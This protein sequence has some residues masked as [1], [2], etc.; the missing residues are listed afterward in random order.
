MGVSVLNGILTGV[1]RV[2]HRGID[3]IGDHGETDALSLTAGIKA[4][5]A[6][7][8]AFEIRFGDAAAVVADGDDDAAALVVDGVAGHATPRAAA[9]VALRRTR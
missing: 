7:G 6:L 9:S 8:Q 2:P 3:D 4:E 1:D 5:A